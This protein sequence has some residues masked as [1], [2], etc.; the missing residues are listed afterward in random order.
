PP[1]WPERIPNPLARTYKTKDDKWIAFICL[2]GF[3]YF[4]DACQVLGRSELV[5]DPRF[6]SARSYAEHG[7]ELARIIA[8]VIASATLAEW[9]PALDSFNGQW[10]RVQD[11]VDIATDPQVLANGYLCDTRVSTGHTIKLATVPLQFNEIPH[12]PGTSPEFNQH[13]ESILTH[14]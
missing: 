2:Q 13:C 7:A 12:P 5:A 10:G 9:M 14:D 1:A 8:D 3:K 4:A 6:E 11:S